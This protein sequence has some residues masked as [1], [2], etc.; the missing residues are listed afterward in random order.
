MRADCACSWSAAFWLCPDCGA[1]NAV[2][3]GGPGPWPWPHCWRCRQ[4]AIRGRPRY[5]ARPFPSRTILSF[6]VHNCRELAAVLAAQ[7]RSPPIA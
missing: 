3:A 5:R 4:P 6:R 7:E 2:P 1:P